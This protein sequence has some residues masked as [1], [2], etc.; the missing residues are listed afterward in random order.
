MH[1]VLAIKG[2]ETEPSR[3]E[4]EMTYTGDEEEQRRSRRVLLVLLDQIVG[5]RV[6]KV[7]T[8]AGT[9]VTEQTL[10]DVIFRELASQERVRPE[11]DLQG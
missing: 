8:G 7:E 2:S 3:E 11:E 5:V 6:R 1:R 9:P 4:S 10:L